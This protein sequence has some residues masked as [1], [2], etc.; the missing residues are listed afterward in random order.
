MYFQLLKHQPVALENAH[1][2]MNTYS[3]NN[4]FENSPST[5]VFKLIEELNRFIPQRKNK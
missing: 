1:K 5:N 4:P 2:L 3:K